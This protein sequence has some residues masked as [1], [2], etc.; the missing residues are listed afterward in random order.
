MKTDNSFA[1]R[2]AR[3]AP[4]PTHELKTWPACF[5]AVESGTKPFDVRENDRNYQVGDV[6]LLREY[7]PETEQYS[8]RTLLRAVS[9][10]LQGGSFGLEAGWCVVGFG[11]LPPLPPG[12]NDTKLW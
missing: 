12:I 5:A 2:L 11:A 7:E 1:A 6:L 8:G 4:P 9:Y 3:P 10:V